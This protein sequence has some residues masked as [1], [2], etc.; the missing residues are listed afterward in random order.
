MRFAIWL[1]ALCCF[2]NS[3]VGQKTGFQEP[4]SFHIQPT[5]PEELRKAAQAD[6]T[7]FEEAQRSK[8][9]AWSNFAAED[10]TM[11]GL[12]GREQIRAQFEKVYLKP[13]FRLLWYPTGGAV[14]GSFVVTTG[15]Y[16]RHALDAESKETVSHG[17]YLTVWQKQ[18][19]GR[20]LYVWDGGE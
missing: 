13:G 9:T 17:R 3:A 16:E 12:N 7:F 14:Y 18:K 20:Y 2:A 5:W 15:S 11:S 6:C 10:A 4:C 1:I 19:N 8:A